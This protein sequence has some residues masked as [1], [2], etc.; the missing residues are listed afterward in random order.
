MADAIGAEC[1]RERS[2][3]LLLTLPE[4]ILFCEFCRS[5]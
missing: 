4:P 3:M 5:G 1:F 2:C